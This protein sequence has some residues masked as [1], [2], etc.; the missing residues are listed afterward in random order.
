DDTSIP[1][2]GD[3]AGEN[4]EKLIAQVGISRY[5]CFIT[6]AVL[7]NPKDEKGNNATPS[8]QEI[9]NCSG[10]LRAQIDLIDPKIIVT[11]GGQA[12]Q[13]LK[14]IE[15]HPYELSEDVRKA[16][17]WMNRIL[18]PLYHPGQRAMIHRSFL[19]QLAD[20]K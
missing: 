12:L 4:F 9:E 11:L 14:L 8:R 3:R 17:H 6:N 2:H 13:A 20:Y 7:C 16:R 15:A 19:N 10:F 1:F 18:I 5:D